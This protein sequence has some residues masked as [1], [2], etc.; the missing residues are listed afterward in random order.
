MI[1]IN[2]DI[3]EGKDHLSLEKDF[4]IMKNVTSVNIACGLHAGDYSQMGKIV[5]FALE[6]NIHIGAHPGYDDLENFGRKEKNLSKESLEHLL[7]YQIGALKTMVEVKGGKLHHVKLHGALYNQSAKDKVMANIVGDVIFKLDPELIVYGP[8]GSVF[9]EVMKA[10]GLKVFNECF[11]DRRYVGYTLAKRE[12][13]GVLKDLME[14]EGHCLKMVTEN[15]LR[16]RNDQEL[17]IFCDTLCLHGD[18]ENSLQVSKA[19]F[20]LLANK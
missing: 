7:I 15:I 18:H 13:D 5:N 1:D 8:Y 2:C 4:E 20:K 11:A 10:K 14:I 6:N 16:D 17:E 3:G 12:E 9:N 19:L